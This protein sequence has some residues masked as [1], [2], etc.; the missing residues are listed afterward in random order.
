MDLIKEKFNELLH[1]LK[2]DFFPEQKHRLR[3]FGRCPRLLIWF[4]LLIFVNGWFSTRM[5]YSVNFGILILRSIYLAIQYTILILIALSAPAEFVLR[6]LEN[7]R[8]VAT[9]KEKEYLFPIF[10]EV[11]ESVK[12][13]S[14]IGNRIKLYILDTAKI[15]AMA[16]GKNSILISRGMISCM[17][18]TEL[19]GILAHEFAHI[20]RGDSQTNMIIMIA[21]NVYIWF[22]I[23]LNAILERLINL[24]PT[25]NFWIDIL[26]AILHIMRFFCLVIINIILFVGGVVLFGSSRKKEYKADEFALKI[27][28]GG[29][30]K[31]SLYKLYDLELSNDKDLLR[32]LFATHPR[33]AYRIENL[34]DIENI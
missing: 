33:T 12:Q 18:E 11:Y 14:R 16:I 24:L 31:S 3:V 21:T 4:I 25:Q 22:I 30:L 23:A 34:E 1:Y 15:T 6:T 32:R 13:N 8:H 29:G 9:Q 19:K 20:V 28:Y 5:M 10:N 26:G 17:N 7:A 2:S 27:G